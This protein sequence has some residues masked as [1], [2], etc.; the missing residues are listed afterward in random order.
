MYNGIGLSTVRGSGTS[1]YVQ[2]NLSHVPATREKRKINYK[3]EADLNK[4]EKI[5]GPNQGIL[6]H[7]KKR[8]I[9]VK[10]AEL[11]DLLVDQNLGEE[12]IN[13]K[14]TAYRKMLMQSVDINDEVE[15]DD[16]GRP[17]IKSTDS[18]QVAK[19]QNERNEK[20]KAAFG[21]MSKEEKEEEEKKFNDRAERETK[22]YQDNQQNNKK[23]KNKQKEKEKMQK[24]NERDRKD[25]SLNKRKRKH[26]P[27]SS[28]SSSS[29]SESSSASSDSSKSSSEDESKKRKISKRRSTEK[30]R[31]EHPRENEENDHDGELQ[32][33]YYRLSSA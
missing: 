15:L 24:K 20:L 28:S 19:M 13:E 27:S 7:E 9:E 25:K 6:D 3:T 22:R 32:V 14:V 5:R 8:K 4:E 30:R 1:G 29:S 11:E 18:H 2:K 16:F 21:I 26:R 23:D 12:E 17:I 33:K 31:Q 10:C